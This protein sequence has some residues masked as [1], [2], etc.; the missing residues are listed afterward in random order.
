MTINYQTLSELLADPTID[1]Q[2]LLNYVNYCNS[3]FG[4]KFIVDLNT[5]KEILDSLLIGTEFTYDLMDGTTQAVDTISHGFKKDSDQWWVST[6][7][8]PI[9]TGTI[10]VNLSDL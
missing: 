10:A 3:K 2:K 8:I 4:N 6:Q 5:S 7:E 9:F 1:H